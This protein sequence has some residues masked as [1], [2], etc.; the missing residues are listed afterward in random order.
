MFLGTGNDQLH[1]YAMSTAW[2]LS[3]ASFTKTTEKIKAIQ[4]YET[5]PNGMFLKPDQTKLWVTGSNRDG[6]NAFSII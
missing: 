6:V 5:V 4:L 3:T 1:E 2:D